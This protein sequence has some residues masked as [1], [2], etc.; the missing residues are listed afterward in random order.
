MDVWLFLSIE[1]IVYQVSWAQNFSVLFIAL[2]HQMIASKSLNSPLLNL[3]FEYGFLKSS[4]V[5]MYFLVLCQ[6][7]SYLLQKHTHTNMSRLKTNGFQLCKIQLIPV[8]MDLNA[9]ILT[10]KV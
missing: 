5:W 1:A 10:V 9:S 7:S 2:L 3:S 4:W 8:M 6:L